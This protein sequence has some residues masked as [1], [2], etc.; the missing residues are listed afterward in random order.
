MYDGDGDAPPCSETMDLHQRLLF[1]L[2]IVSAMRFLKKKRIVHRDLSAKNCLV[3]SAY[4]VKVS[5]FGL[6]RCFLSFLFLV[7][8]FLVQRMK[9]S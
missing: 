1:S 6:A 4:T 2:D 9:A 7:S 5:D 3:T 8:L